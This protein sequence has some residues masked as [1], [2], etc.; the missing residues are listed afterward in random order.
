MPLNVKLRGELLGYQLQHAEPELALIGANQLEA[1]LGAERPPNG[2]PVLVGPESAPPGWLALGELRA[3]APS[4]ALPVVDQPAESLAL[5]MYTSGTTGRPKGVMIPRQAQLHHGLNYRELLGIEPGETCYTYLPL[6]HVTAMGSTLGSLLAGASVA[7]EAGFNPFGFWERT[8][9]YGAVVFTFVGSILNALL[10][11]PEQ[12]DDR[13]NPVRRAVGAATPAWLWRSFERRFG[14]EIV[15]TYGQTEMVALWL[16]PP[17][18]SQHSPERERGGFRSMR[19]PPRSRSGLGPSASGTV[20]DCLAAVQPSS[21]HA[22]RAK[23]GTVGVPAGGRFEVRIVGP[24][25]HELGP[26]ERGEI[27]IRPSDPLDMMLGYFRD[28]AATAAALRP[29]GWYY[30]GDL[31]VRDEDGYVAYA[32]RLKD[33]IRRRGEM[34]SAYEIERVANAHPLVLESAAVAVPA[35]DGE[36]EIKLCVVPRADEALEARTVWEHCR[37][38]LPAFM[39][40]RWIELRPSLPKT[41]TERVRKPALAEEGVANCWQAGAEALGGL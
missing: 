1:F 8:R 36:E 19:R 13:D 28:P 31:G 41:A 40:P 2:R 23:V 25:G 33:C 38:A 22:H 10:H 21:D 24:D 34:I 5:I 26:G 39:L 11:R 37:R 14:L 16:G 32:G 7:L 20:S 35:E 12:P 15:E 18:A 27:A 4:G 17:S 29:D 30:S 6:Y 9:R 3:A